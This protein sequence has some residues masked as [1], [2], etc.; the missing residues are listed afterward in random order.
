MDTVNIGGRIYTLESIHNLIA[1]TGKQAEDPQQAA[2]AA[3]ELSALQLFGQLQQAAALE[4]IAATLGR[5]VVIVSS[6]GAELNA[7]RAPVSNL[8]ELANH[9]HKLLHTLRHRVIET[10]KPAIVE[11]AKG[12]TLKIFFEA[13]GD[14]QWKYTEGGHPITEERLIALLDAAFPP[15]YGDDSKP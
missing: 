13:A 10:G 12:P 4:M 7:V 9:D 14:P 3:R 5:E 8:A 15:S 2:G 6:G 1:L 11:P